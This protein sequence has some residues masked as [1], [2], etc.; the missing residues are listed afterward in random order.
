MAEA[1]HRVTLWVGGQA[2]EGW[3]NV[4]VTLNLDHMAGDFILR[5]T[6][7]YLKD[8]QLEQHP[9]DAGAAC[10]V[11]ID[12]ETVMTGWVDNPIPAFDEKSNIVTVTG[13]DTTGDLVDCSAE[14]K[15]YLNQT[16]E[17]VARDM[18]APFGIKV[19]VTTDT[20]APFRRVA[21]NTGD[22][23]QTCIERMCRQRG[24]L[25]WSDGLG[26]L[27]IGRG[28][29][30][31]P[32]AALKRGNNVLAA[33]APNN[34]AA[35]FSEIIVRGTRETPDSSDPTAGSQ[36][37]GVA[38]DV[39]VKRHR[40]KIMVPETQGAIINLTE[41]AAH[42]QRVAQGKSRC[43]SVTVLGWRHEGGLWRPGQTV[44]FSDSRL[45]IN[46]NWLVA[47]VAFIKSDDDGTV[48]KLNLYPPGAF[49][50]LAQPEEE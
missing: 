24:V 29:V 23:V 41:R 43:V 20:G 13:R 21:V 36:E 18:C 33:T 39:A 44:A 1:E 9:I 17:A 16:L 47:N 48:T 19:V 15:E 14:V 8:G 35:R 42:E 26:N 34:F 45:R 3:E 28:T 32:V 11:V 2:H 38:R 40:P 10:R 30:G 22:T 49:D 6:D 37:Q 5:L 4:A 12:D 25:A 7:E 46:G 31:E 27:V 50:L